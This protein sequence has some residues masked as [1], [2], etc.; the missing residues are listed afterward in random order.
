[1]RPQRI[2]LIRHARSVANEDE[3]LYQLIPDSLIPLSS[4]GRVQA[5]EAGIRLKSILVSKKAQFYVSP[6]LRTRQTFSAIVEHWHDIQYRIYEEPRLREQDWGNLTNHSRSRDI[7][8][9]QDTVGPF[10]Y[11]I[12]NGESGADVYDRVSTF[13]ETMH[14][15]FLKPD[16]PENAILVTHGLTMRLFLMRWFHWTVEEF[17]SLKNPPNCHIA[18]MILGP[19]GK[20]HLGESDGLTE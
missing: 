20:Y 10:F 6:Y 12:P 1:M 2:F 14:R 18:E 8:E 4:N 15:D 11:R 19:D 3:T 5:S 17:H 9:E 13:L 16:Y 7:K